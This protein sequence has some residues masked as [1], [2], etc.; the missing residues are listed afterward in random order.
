MAASRR[1]GTASLCRCRCTRTSSRCSWAWADPKGAG[2]RRC[3]GASGG[4]G[5]PS[6]RRTSGPPWTSYGPTARSGSLAPVPW[7]RGLPPTPP[8]KAYRSGGLMQVPWLFGLVLSRLSRARR[9]PVGEVRP[10]GG[11]TQRRARDP[12]RSRLLVANGGPA[13]GEGLLGGRACSG[14]GPAQGEGL[15]GGRA[16]SGGGPARGEG[17]GAQ[18]IGMSG[19]SPWVADGG[20]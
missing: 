4:P 10:V 5:T 18:I 6:R 8:R 12:G 2:R 9:E 20:S 3:W 14:G 11:W 13:R 16:C 17:L 7:L 19:A 1:V 15:L